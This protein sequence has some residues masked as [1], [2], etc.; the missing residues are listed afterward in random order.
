MPTFKNGITTKFVANIIY[1]I[2]PTFY[3]SFLFRSYF[4]F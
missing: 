2:K 3:K 4:T 1:P